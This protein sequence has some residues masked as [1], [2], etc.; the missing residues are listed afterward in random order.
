MSRVDDILIAN[1]LPPRDS[2]SHYGT[3]GMKWG[4][5]KSRSSG[6]KTSSTPS[7]R[8]AKAN[9]D[10]EK[11]PNTF[12]SR[13]DN[14]RLTDAEL[15]RKLNRIRMETEYAR[16]TTPNK[17]GKN[18]MQEILADE[19]K[20]VAK[21]LASRAANVALQLALEKAAARATGG[22]AEFLTA[23]ANQGNKKKK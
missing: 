16:L 21:T 10:T 23:M 2:F 4:I 18:L 7:K 8:P 22:N 17:K 9:K 20:K 14:R 1:G 15:N 11:R 5:R 6:G 19:G 13:P 3:V 12:R